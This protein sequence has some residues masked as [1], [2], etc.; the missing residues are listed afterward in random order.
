MNTRVF[1]LSGPISEPTNAPAVSRT[2]IAFELQ[3]N[4]RLLDRLN[5]Q[6][7]ELT[8]EIAQLERRLGTTVTEAV[9]DAKDT[10]DIPDRRRIPDPHGEVLDREPFDDATGPM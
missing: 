9:T 8:I 5:K 1:T 3:M 6:R 7:D 10:A 4:R 2:A